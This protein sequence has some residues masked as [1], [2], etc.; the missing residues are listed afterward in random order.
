MDTYI[1]TKE[2]LIE[3]VIEQYAVFLN[4]E[5]A[6]LILSYLEG[7]G[8]SLKIVDG[9]LTRE[10]VDSVDGETEICTIKDVLYGIQLWHEEFMECVTRAILY[11]NGLEEY[12]MALC[13]KKRYLSD[14]VIIDRLVSLF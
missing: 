12:W 5:E 4:G 6:D 8:Y 13:D 2:Q 10:D 11:P 1:G 14:A 9:K 7:H 3:L